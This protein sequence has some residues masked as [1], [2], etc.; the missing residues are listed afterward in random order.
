MHGN[1]N[2]K[3]L[4]LYFIVQNVILPV[5]QPIY[6]WYGFRT[7]IFSNEM[8]TS[9]AL[10]VG[11]TYSWSHVPVLLI[12]STTDF[13]PGSQTFIFTLRALYALEGI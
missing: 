5:S 2:I 13:L 4:S 6:L 9:Y 11:E 1:S 8:L 12:Y 3:F 7:K 10:S